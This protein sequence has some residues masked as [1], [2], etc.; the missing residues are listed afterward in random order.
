MSYT[1]NFTSGSKP[2]ILVNDSTFNTT[3]LP[4]ILIGKSVLN[5]GEIIQE[6]YIKILE[7]FDNTTAPL[8]PTTGMLW[9]DSSSVTSRQLKLYDGTSWKQVS[10]IN[11]GPLPGTGL[12]MGQLWNYNTNEYFW[13]GTVWKKI[14]TDSLPLTGGTVTG[15]IVLNVSPT[16]S[17]H[18]TNKLYV[19]NEITTKALLVA[20]GGTVSGHISLSLVPSSGNHL[21]NKTYVDNALSTQYSNVVTN[22]VMKSGGTLTGFLTL[23][24]NPTSNMHAVTKQYVDSALASVGTGLGY[25]PVNKAGDTMTSFLTLNANPTNNLHAATKQYVDNNT[26]FLKLSSGGTVTGGTIFSGSVTVS[27]VA[28]F[29]NATGTSFTELPLCNVVPTSDNQLVNKSYVD[30]TCIVPGSTINNTISLNNTV[31]ITSDYN[32]I[33]RIYGDTRYVRL[34]GSGTITGNLTLDTGIH[35]NNPNT[36]SNNNHLV[37]K[38]YV[39][40][41]F[42]QKTGGVMTGNIEVSVAPTIDQHLA[43]KLYVDTKVADGTIFTGGTILNHLF[44]N[45][46]FTEPLSSS[47]VVTYGY[48]I[49]NFIHRD[50]VTKATTFREKASYN[51]IYNNTLTWAALSNNDI[52]TKSVV[53]EALNDLVM[54]SGDTMT[55]FLTLHA[56]PTNNLHAATKEYVDGFLPLTGGTTTGKIVYDSS[57][58]ISNNYDLITKKYADDNYVSLSGDTMT[59]KIVYDNSLVISA[60]YDLVTKKYVTDTFVPIAGGT[61]TGKIVYDNSLVISADYDLVTKKYVTDTFVPIAGGTFSNNFTFSGT[62]TLSGNTVFSTNLPQYT[63]SSSPSVSTDLVTKGYVDNINT[64]FVPSTYNGLYSTDFINGIVGTIFETNNNNGGTVS[65]HNVNISGL[66][67]CV[68]LST[69]TSANGGAE[70]N[71]GTAVGILTNNNTYCLLQTHIP[72]LSTGTEEFKLGFGLVSGGSYKNASASPHIMF[73][74]DRTI[75]TNWLVSKDGSVITTSVTVTAATNNIFKI[76]YDHASNACLM[77]INGTLVHTFSTVNITGNT[78]GFQSFI[79]KSVGTTSRSLLIDKVLY[80]KLTTVSSNWIL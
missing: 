29:T 58:V 59:G 50:P 22:F 67:G 69:S 24:S 49:N 75:S 80:G 43:N 13:N 19:D 21:T 73:I 36:P 1:I 23:H 31:N 8:H 55:G 18:L 44:I 53:N 63:G 48:L 60:D 42:L 14:D 6:N 33:T 25:T 79:L 56:N 66:Y 26:L 11:N 10:I 68:N 7:N 20:S 5:W 27:G 45:A 9:S 37:N 38:L 4:I 71:D 76:Y 40:T 70:I 46:T 35:I 32:L 39:D 72:I 3:S 77:Y 54:V 16:L 47:Q 51:S 61:V 30:A 17:S 41:N 28:S 74:Y 62:V 78:Y 2:T 12:Y 64:S 57:L 65:K 52:V 34:S 15:P